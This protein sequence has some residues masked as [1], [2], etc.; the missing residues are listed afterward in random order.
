[1]T[2]LQ[3]YTVDQAAELLA[4]S[5]TTVE[6]MARDGRLPGIKPGGSWV[7][8]AGALAR[9]LDELAL[10]EAEQRRKP[11]LPVAVT[12]PACRKPGRQ[13]R[14]LPKLV[15]LRG[16]PRLAAPPGLEPE[17]GP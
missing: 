16:L 17:S 3:V 5:V 1:M 13:K 7:F 10:E 14:P 4:C 6:A 8:P 2:T 15:D 11:A 9:R 12:Q